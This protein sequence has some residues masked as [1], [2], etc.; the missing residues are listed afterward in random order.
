[1]TAYDREDAD[2]LAER[3]T[4]LISHLDGALD[5]EMLSAMQGI[6]SM[7]EH[8]ATTGPAHERAVRERLLWESLGAGGAVVAPD[9]GAI[10]AADGLVVDLQPVWDDAP[11]A[12]ADAA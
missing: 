2:A 3:T 5:E 11:G 6:W 9:A 7:L 10:A 12:D 4:R 1:M 8:A